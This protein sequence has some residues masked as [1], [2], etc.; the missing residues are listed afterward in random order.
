MESP[1]ELLYSLHSKIKIINKKITN[2]LKQYKLLKKSI[3]ILF[4]FFSFTIFF[5]I[6]LLFIYIYIIIK[7]I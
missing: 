3:I 5:I 1:E 2:S 4:D 6:Y 7:N